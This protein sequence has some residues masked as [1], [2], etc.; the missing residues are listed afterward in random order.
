MSGF[1]QRLLAAAAACLVAGATQAM[2]C[3]APVAAAQS[4]TGAN[5]LS[6]LGSCVSTK[7]KLDVILM[8]DETESLIHQ[9]KGGNIDPNTPG[10]DA[11]HNRV[12]AAQSFVNQLLARHND[13][14]VDVRIRVAGFGQEYKSGVTD[15]AYGDWVRLDDGSVQG[16]KSTIASFANR[17]S[18]QYT[19]YANAFEGAYQDFPR[20]GSE[21]SC[22]MLVTF[23]DGALTAQEGVDA[24]QDAVCRPNGIT[25]KYRSAGITNIGIGL[26]DPKN[27]SDFN[28][29][30][31]ITEGTGSPCG[32]LEPNGAFFPADSVGSLFA[33]FHQ[34]LNTGG[35]FAAETAAGDP[36]EFV[37]D[38]S[39]DSVHFTAIAKDDLGPNAVLKLIAPDGSEIELKGEGDAKVGGASISWVASADPVQ[40]AEGEL[41]L[42]KPEGWVG[43]WQL[44][45]VGFSE[46]RSDHR[47]FNSVKIQPD[48]QLQL[49]GPDGLATGSLNVRSKDPVTVQLVDRNGKPRELRGTATVDLGFLPNGNGGRT[50]LLSAADISNGQPVLVPLQQLPEL[51]ATGVLQA[52]VHVVTAPAP[53]APGTALDPI[54]GEVPVAVSRPDMPELPG[55][56]SFTMETPEISTSI[57][58]V[59]PG[60]VWIPAGTTLATETLPEG[61]DAIDVSSQ[62]ADAGTALE[63][64]EG[65]EASLPVTISVAQLRDGFVS[66]TIPVSISRADGSEETVVPIAATGTM[67]IPLNKTAFTLAFVAA[68][69]L[70]LLIPLALLYLVRYLTARIPEQ[71]FGAQRISLH[72]EGSALRYDGAVAPTIDFDGA[73][74]NQIHHDGRVASALGHQLK[75]HSFQAN[76]LAGSSVIVETTPSIS[77]TGL[78]KSDRAA[79]PLAVQGHWF[80]AARDGN[81]ELIVLPRLPIEHA[82]AQQL[83]QNTVERAPELA[84]QLQQQI[85]QQPAVGPSDAW[86]GPSASEPPQQ[87]SDGWGTQESQGSQDSWGD[88][89]NWGDRPTWN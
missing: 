35:E 70:G 10:A 28:L 22:K 36:F 46:D 32:K 16:V 63:L 8:M 24:A 25:D 69:L 42:S 17:T 87:R 72:F 74:R 19:N 73:S 2:S 84:A 5:A 79:L 56:L 13:E 45:F 21:D 54:T 85:P 76:P 51:P 6:A 68:L 15:P 82:A 34:A 14:G 53:D 66:G 3:V 48:L 60:K 12:P 47:V 58:V 18:E 50:E 44:K 88:K 20:S 31:G 9:V 52:S 89:P 43:K 27:P 57:P 77:D 80:I 55:A 1:R 65:E 41:S 33:S 4:G 29:F 38:D 83:V 75:V 49:H 71:Y 67:S 26:S 62:H 39:I 59:G 64:G 30:A 78:Q 86:Q 61:V 23:T 81:L 7:G 37:L 11:D 40:K